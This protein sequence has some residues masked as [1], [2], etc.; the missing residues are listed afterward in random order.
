MGKKIIWTVIIIIFLIFAG[1]YFGLSWDKKSPMQK[2]TNFEECARA[3]YPVGES[4]PR[5][6]WAPDGRHFVEDIVQGEFWGTILG[7]VVLGP[8]CPVQDPTDSNCVDKPYQTRLALTT[9]DGSKVIKEF[10]SDANGKFSIEV[11]PGEYAIR[12]AA[13]ADVLPYCQ[14]DGVVVLEPNGYVEITVRCDTGIR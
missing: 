12:S 7:T 8:N 9:K 3:G 5:Q 13:A 11:Q 2:V 6:C 14:S 4:Y 10:N 1:V